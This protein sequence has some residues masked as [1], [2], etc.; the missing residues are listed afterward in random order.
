M[1]AGAII[2]AVGSIVNKGISIYEMRQQAAIEEK[3]RSDELELARIN[4]SR[5]TQVAS[6]Q[7]DTS[8][9]EG[10]QWVINTLR[11][12]RPSIT[13]YALILVTIFWFSASVEDKT[14]IVS[15]VLDLASMATAWWFGDRSLK[16]R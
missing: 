12:V 11:M 7:H 6:Y 2:G 10:S 4:A 16:N 5:D 15:S 14:L 13:G 9:G 1:I 3:K 8:M